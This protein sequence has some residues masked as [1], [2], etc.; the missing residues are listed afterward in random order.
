VYNPCSPKTV[1]C[2][3]VYSYLPICNYVWFIILQCASLSSRRLKLLPTN[4]LALDI[5]SLDVPI[6]AAEEETL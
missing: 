6:V 5:Y 4:H 1:Y 3:S 2:Y